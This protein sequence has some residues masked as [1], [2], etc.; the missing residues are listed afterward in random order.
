MVEQV[1][2][3]RLEG[4]PQ[5]AFQVNAIYP[6]KVPLANVATALLNNQM[7]YFT[8]YQGQ[9]ELDILLEKPVDLSLFINGQE[10]SLAQLPVKVWLA[11][12]LSKLTVNGRNKLQL[13]GT[14]NEGKVHLKIPFLV[15]Q[16]HAEDTENRDNDGF[17][18][19]DNLINNQI[20]FGFPSAQLVVVH[21]GQ[22]VKQSTYGRVNSYSPDGKRLTTAPKVTDETLYDI[23][24]NTKM[25]ATNLA[26]QKLVYEKKL[27]IKSRVADIFP[28]FKDQ[29]QDKIKG[30]DD[31]T[32]Q[33]I[34]EHQAGFPADPQYFD[35]H[36]EL[37]DKIYTQNRDEILAKIIATPLSYQP[38]TKTIYSD[39]DYMLLGLIIEK[40]TG[41]R[42]D[43]YVRENI[44]QPLGLKHI[45]FNPLQ[46]GFQRAETAATELDGNTFAG[47]ADFNH[48]RTTTIQGEV[49]DSKAYYTMKG[50]SGH[51]GLFSNATDLA[52]LAQLVLN[53]GGYGRKQLFDLDTLAEFAK[54]KSTDP[55]FGL[56]WRRQADSGYARIFS[57][58]PTANTIGHTGWTGTLSLVDF[59]QQTVIILLTN[60]RNSPLIDGQKKDFVGDHYLV[61]KYG[62][63]VSLVYSALDGDSFAANNQK[64]WGLIQ[65]RY[66]QLS[67]QPELATLA[68][69]HDLAAIYQTLVDRSQQDV[70]AKNVLDSALGQKIKNFVNSNEA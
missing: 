38:G 58:A 7:Q 39:V 33:D 25:W 18:L 53:H 70:A 44:Y 37:A 31:L 15:L 14:F 5:G 65:T 69:K 32:I 27:T 56:G 63:I 46:H 24:S 4:E 54:P 62:D 23:A 61:G 55:T 41:Q 40:I 8:S 17:N 10:I 67:Q 51:A 1:T 16:N 3:K 49:H 59:E 20:K 28:E 35:N 66:Q 68:D 19:I 64:L 9:G 30:K 29:S 52:V 45:A 43:D 48:V 26:L 11:L 22:I 50:I 60:K 36:N 2:F 42:E 12:D 47:T 13:A 6:E 34:L 21:N 57:N